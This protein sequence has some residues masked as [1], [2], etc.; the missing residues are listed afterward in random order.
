M[1][2]IK[3]HYG[4]DKD[5]HVIHGLHMTKNYSE[6]TTQ[7][8]FFVCFLYNLLYLIT[9]IWDDYTIIDTVASN[10]ISLYFPIPEMLPFYTGAGY[11]DSISNE[12]KMPQLDFNNGAAPFTDNDIHA[13]IVSRQPKEK[14][15]DGYLSGYMMWY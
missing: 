11:S 12:D 15:L 7:D 3:F 6:T 13:K 14:T 9:G 1:I 8:T 4:L 2:S 5:L 10:L